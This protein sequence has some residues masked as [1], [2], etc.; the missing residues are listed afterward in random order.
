MQILYFFHSSL[1]ASKFAEDRNFAYLSMSAGSTKCRSLLESFENGE[2]KDL[3][4]AA[5]S[6]H[7]WGLNMDRSN[8]RIMLDSDLNEAERLQS[9]GR[10][11]RVVR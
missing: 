1:V 2:L 6:I 8:V 4:V 11:R 3:V 5:P 9:L 7:G 10:I